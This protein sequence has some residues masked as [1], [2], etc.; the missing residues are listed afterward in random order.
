MLHLWRAEL[1][2]PYALAILETAAQWL[3]TLQLASVTP[4]TTIQQLC[5]SA[6][7]A[8]RL[9][10][11]ASDVHQLSMQL[12]HNVEVGRFVRPR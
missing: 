2:T 9:I 12:Q 8:A 6:G 1:C 4:D 7:N 10:K 3:H 5:Q 11:L